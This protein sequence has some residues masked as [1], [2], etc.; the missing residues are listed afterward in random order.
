MSMVKTAAM[1]RAYGSRGRLTGQHRQVNPNR[2]RMTGRMSK[3][4]VSV[5]AMAAKE[6][7]VEVE[8]PLGMKLGQKTGKV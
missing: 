7:T 6:L 8:K 5:V 4:S 2:N 3:R 1:D